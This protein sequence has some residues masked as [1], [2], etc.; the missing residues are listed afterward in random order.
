M[1]LTNNEVRSLFFKI[2]WPRFKNQNTVVGKQNGKNNNSK[3]SVKL[4]LL[5]FPHLVKTVLEPVSLPQ[6]KTFSHPRD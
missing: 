4:K 1:S 3:P 6:V 2:T 5:G